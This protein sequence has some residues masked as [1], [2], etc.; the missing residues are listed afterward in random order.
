[1]FLERM[2]S[3]C[4]IQAETITAYSKHGAALKEELGKKKLS[5]R[6]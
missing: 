2:G 5:L 6:R 4:F 3:A 1:M